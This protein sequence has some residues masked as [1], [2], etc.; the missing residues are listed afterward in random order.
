VVRVDSVVDDKLYAY[1][2]LPIPVF[3]L[4]SPSDSVF[5]PYVVAFDWEDANPWDELKHDLWV[6]TSLSFH[7]D[8]TVV[9]DSL[10]SNQHTDTLEVQRFYWKVRSYN[11]SLER[12][13]TQTWTFLSA[14]RGDVNGDKEV[15]ISDVV[16]LVNYVL[17]SGPDPVPEPVVGDANCD[18]N[19]DITDAVYLVNYL[20]KDGPPPCS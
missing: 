4:L 15:A 16:H 14:I 19:V 2:H 9:Y 8:S 13:S 10:L 18:D 1:I 20:F 11:S 12:W 7:P 5:I 17:K 3:S 6:S